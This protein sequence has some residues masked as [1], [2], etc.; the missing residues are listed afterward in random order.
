MPDLS[1]IE[2][3]ERSIQQIF[4]DD[5][6]FEIPPYQRPYA[7]E[8]DQARDLLSDLL[9]AMDNGV[10]GEVYFLGSIVLIKKPGSPDAKVVDGQQRLT[11]LTILLS[12]MRD[13][14]GDEEVRFERRGYVHQKASADK[15]TADRYRL[16][17]RERDRPFFQKFVQVMGGTRDLPEVDSLEGSQQRI[18]ENAR[19]FRSQ[20]AATDEARRNRLFAFIIQRCYIVVVAVPTQD[21]AR[22]IFTVLNARGMDLTATDILKADLLERAGAAREPDLAKRWE[23]VELALGRD[24]F[25]ELFG[26]IRMIFERE[27]PRSALEVGFPRFVPPFHGDA[28]AF[29][30]DTLEPIANEL[31]LIA[32]GAWLQT[33]FGADA[34]KALRSLNRIDNKDWLPPVLLRLWK[35]K[36]G[37][38]DVVAEFL[39]GLERLAYFLFVTRAD[40]NER[41]IRF[42]SVMDQIDPRPG[43]IAQGGGLALTP[44]EQAE[45]VK[46][47]S[48]PLY[49]KS[50]VCKPVL[51]RLDEALSSGGAIYEDPTSIEHVLPQKVDDDSE[52]ATLFPDVEVRAAWTHR[53][54]NLV[55]LTKRINTRASNWDFDRKKSEYFTSNDGASPFPLTQGVLQTPKWTPDHLEHRQQKLLDA[56]SDIWNLEQ[57]VP[58]EAQL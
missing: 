18:A 34:A 13:L 6:S 51:Q 32:N 27:K 37:D 56:L 39:I 28:D 57:T 2:A 1:P 38:K 10:S 54:A 40:V 19:Y 46:D 20:L 41:I 22:R 50:R 11:T 52:W 43:K 55:F 17:L 33:Q 45:F 36:A 12:V 49:T 24:K 7:W 8:L 44:D 35:R 3:H 53:L 4:C 9:D 21:A 16:L 5:Y 42:A 47:L 48:G 30:T 29:V 58:S 31:E 25:V 15:G 26:H 23:E 14:T